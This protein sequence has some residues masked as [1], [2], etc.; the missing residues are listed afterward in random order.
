VPHGGVGKDG[1]VEAPFGWLSVMILHKH[2]LGIDLTQCIK[3][4]P[5]HSS[6]DAPEVATAKS[7]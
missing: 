3:K 4:L 1:C 7:R 6:T 2:L 5:E